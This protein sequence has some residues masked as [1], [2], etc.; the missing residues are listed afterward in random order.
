VGWLDNTLYV[1]AHPD[2]EGE[3]TTR[4]QRFSMALRLITQANNG[5]MPEF[6]QAALEQVLTDLRGIPTAIYER[7]PPLE[8]EIDPVAALEPEP[9]AA[10]VSRAPA[11][12]AV[13]KAA[14][15][16]KS[17]STSGAKKTT[18]SPV[19]TK[20]TSKSAK[21]ST[22]IDHKTTSPGYYRGH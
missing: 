19:A 7:L 15:A 12:A 10:P 21:S 18:K 6:D 22:K 16:A 14:V 11:K 17:S 4:D 1:E 9:V 3:E 13:P 2:L 5:E 20:I 8:G